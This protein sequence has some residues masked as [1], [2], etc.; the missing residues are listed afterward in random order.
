MTSQYR[1]GEGKRIALFILVT[2][3][4]LTLMY[5]LVLVLFGAHPEDPGL[6]S[7]SVLRDPSGE[8]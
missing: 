4:T 6:S 5:L 1:D 2:G 7:V 3:D 8:A